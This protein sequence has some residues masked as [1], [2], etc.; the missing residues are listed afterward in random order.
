MEFL[1][2]GKRFIIIIGI[3]MGLL[4]GFTL[5]LTASGGTSAKGSFLPWVVAMPAGSYDG[6]WRTVAE[7]QLADLAGERVIVPQTYWTVSADLARLS[8]ILDEADAGSRPVLFLPLPA[9]AYGRFILEPAPVM[10]PELAARYPQIRTFAGRG[11]DDPAATV[12]LDL[13]SHGFHAMISQLEDTF[14]VDPY[15]RADREHYI[16]YSARSYTVPGDQM[17]GL[18]GDLLADPEK[19]AEIAQLVTQGVVPTGDELRTYRLAVAASAEYT[20]FHGGTVAGGLAAIVTAVNRVTG[21]Y[22]R[23]VAIRLVLVA[24]NDTIVYTNAATDPYTNDN[25]TALLNENQANLDA[26]IGSGNYDIGHVFTTGS[27]GL[28]SLG[29][30][31]QGGSK[32]RGT[33]GQINPVGDPFY[34]DYVAHEIGHQFGGNHTFNGDEGSCAGNRNAATA[35]EPGSGSTIMAYAGIC[36]SQDLQPNSDDHFHT[37][38]YDEIVAYSTMG[39]GS[40]CAVVTNTGNNIPTANAGGDYTIP[41]NTPFRLSGSGSDDDPADVLSYNWEELD[42]GSAGPPDSSTQ[43]PYF[44]S[45]PSVNS[46]IRVFPR[47]GDL[48]NNTTAIG[49]V[50]PTIGDTL[51]FRLT[52]R[53]N[54]LNGGGVNYDAMQV[55]VDG[56]SG[57]FRV[58]NPNTLIAWEVGQT[59]MVTWDVA[60]TTAAP[61]NCSNA[62][63]TLS[64]DGGFNYPITLL[65]SIGNDGSENVTVPNNPTLSARVQVACVG[66]IFFDISDINFILLPHADAGGPYTTAE[67][68]AVILD[69]SASSLSDVYEWDFDNDGFFDD[70]VGLNPAFDLVGQDGIYPVAVRVTKDGISNVDTTTVTVT[71]VAPSVTLASDAPQAENTA[72][73]ISGLVSD[74]GWLEVLTATIDWGD[75]TPLEP[76]VGLLE[77]IPP[78]A[79]LTFDMPHIYGDNGSFTVEVCGFDDDTVTCQSIV[80]DV[81]NVE[82]TAKINEANA[83]LINGNPVILDQVNEPVDFNGRATDPGSDDLTLSW[84]WDDGLP[85]PDISTLYLVNPPGPDPLPSPTIQ[86][87]DLI[88]LQT[89]MFSDVCVYDIQF[90]AADDDGGA[91]VTTIQ[92]IIVGDSQQPRHTGY[93]QHQYQG[94]GYIDFDEATLRC[95]LVITELVSDVFSEVRDASTLAAAYQVLFLGQNGGS[96]QEKFDRELL[97]AWLNFANGSLAYNQSF[98]IDHDGAADGTLASLIAA[99]EAVRLD[100]TATTAELHDQRQ[101]LHLLSNPN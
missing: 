74:P 66:N 38:S 12:R 47:L 84:D 40:S 54:A 52:V 1:T 99:A 85:A 58:T 18:A 71:N 7:S 4:L 42:L 95:Y 30:T 72:V 56:G 13:T 65:A 27:G 14:Y 97:T 89:H 59:R 76:V 94:N 44:R 43:P 82:P 61:V 46:P 2:G 79:T 73:T 33:T 49:E 28:A 69:A 87:R 10:A 36:G 92:V 96:E 3:L 22:E 8:A 90:S 31:C 11:L 50:L 101:I 9:G 51:D 53:D 80:V 21:I 19:V 29:V 98:D 64:L 23:E 77:N 75:G 88:D 39:A 34:V 26:V 15:S 91:A 32:A 70:A 37:A 63:I 24:N 17:I 93:W 25:A 60:G 81:T 62:A 45:W 48:V 6:V 57:P 68:V 16:V 55:M 78:E 5:V 41:N 83:V 67:G 100:P 86:P 35:Y 20:T